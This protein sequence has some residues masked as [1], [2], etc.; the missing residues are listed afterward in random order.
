MTILS[1]SVLPGKL[2][3][4]KNRNANLFLILLFIHLLQDQD[5]YVQTDRIDNIDVLN[6]NFTHISSN[7]FDSECVSQAEGR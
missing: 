4:K 6:E 5:K 7:L 3:I 2:W 1:I